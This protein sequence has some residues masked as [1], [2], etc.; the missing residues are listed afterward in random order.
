MSATLGLLNTHVGAMFGRPKTM[1]LSTTPRALLF[2]GITICE[3]AHG[4]AKVL[5]NVMK[6]RKVQTI[7]PVDD[8]SLRFALFGHV[9][10]RNG[11]RRVLVICD[12]IFTLKRLNLL[13]FF[14]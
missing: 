10:S 8:G 5:C 12:V 9:S 11:Y 6:E 14:T 3:D 13:P 7:Q 1:F 4:V 2:E